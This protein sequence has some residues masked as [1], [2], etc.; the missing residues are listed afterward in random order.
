MC[1]GD[2]CPLK[3]TCYRFLAESD[4]EFQTYMAKPPYNVEEENC[5]FYWKTDAN[6]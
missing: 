1:L 3:K 6:K 2:D 5:D 4:G